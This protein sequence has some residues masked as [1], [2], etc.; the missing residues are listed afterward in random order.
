[1]SKTKITKREDPSQQWRKVC[2][3]ELRR[4]RENELDHYLPCTLEE[5]VELFEKTDSRGK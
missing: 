4:V 2:A 5:A 1:M 3:E